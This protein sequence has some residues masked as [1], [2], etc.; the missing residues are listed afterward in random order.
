MSEARRSKSPRIVVATSYEV[1][2]YAEV[3]VPDDKTQ[4]A[5]FLTWQRLHLCHA[6]TCKKGTEILS[7]DEAATRLVEH[8]LSPE[9]FGIAEDG[10]ELD[11]PQDLIKSLDDS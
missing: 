4:L 1:V 11:E 10:S 9:I 5:D 7:A 3:E 6:I 2:V 8:G